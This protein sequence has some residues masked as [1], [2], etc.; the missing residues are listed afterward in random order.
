MAKFKS[1]L[2]ETSGTSSGE[3][4]SGKGKELVATISRGGICQTNFPWTTRENVF[5]FGR[6][7]SV[8]WANS[9][10]ESPVTKG[11]YPELNFL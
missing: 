2:I 6:E 9:S 4:P 3:M 10:L 8:R 7:S 11:S 1:G 5:V